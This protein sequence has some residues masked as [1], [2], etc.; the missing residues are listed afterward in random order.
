MG[1]TAV[2]VLALGAGGAVQLHRSIP[3]P[4][5]HSLLAASFSVPGTAASLPWPDEGQAALYL[6]GFGWLG[7][8]ESEGS[9]P[10]ASVTKMMT[11]L[12]VLRDHPLSPGMAGPTITISAADFALY[13]SG[14]AAGDSVVR[15]EAGEAISEL[16]LLEGLLLPSGDNLAE[17]LADWESGSEPAFVEQM[18]RLA[19]SLHLEHT[20]FADSSGLNSGSVSC[21]RDLVGLA[22]VAMKNPVFAAIVAMP[23][24]S[25]PVAG[26]VR[27]YN[28]ILGQDGIV[29]I[30]TGWTAQ[31]LG[32]LV[33]AADEKVGGRPVQLIGAVLGQP[34]GPE[35]ALVA[36]GRTAAALLTAANDELRQVQV[37]SA[38]TVVGRITSGWM[39]RVTVRVN[40][41]IRLIGEPGARLELHL[42]FRRLMAPLRSGAEVGTLTITTPGR[43]ELHKPV[44]VTRKLVSPSWWWRL[45]RSL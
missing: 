21:A 9:V 29:G 39:R 18:N 2:L 6:S 35:S 12:V 28:P 19:A 10:I 25:L 38:G 8:T 11:A 43:F 44:V 33:F 13:Q 14:L 30:K 26:T 40:H 23:A 32:C 16:Q 24:V 1:G 17:V 45:T 22:T 4:T 41:T 3:A 7:S 27:N 31:A 36:A 20:H 37:P 15:V 42:H 5:A 34:G